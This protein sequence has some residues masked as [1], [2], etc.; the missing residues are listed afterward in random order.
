MKNILKHTKKGILMVALLATV[1]GF[2]NDAKGIIKKDARKTSLIIENVKVGN[3]LSIKDT[4]GVVLYKESIDTNGVYTKGFDLTALPDGKYNFELEKDL[5]I[6]TI[7]FSVESN[8]VS[9]NRTEETTYYKPFIKQE[10]DLVYITKLDLN[11]EVA[12]INI[13]SYANGDYN[14]SHSEKIEGGKV[15]EKVFKLE[16]GNYKIEINSANK[17]YTAFINN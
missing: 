11:Q 6:N 15:I 10:D 9:I 14:L 12:S 3:L 5:E 16:E 7:P 4:N 17:E 8:I 2:A 13:Y 1:T